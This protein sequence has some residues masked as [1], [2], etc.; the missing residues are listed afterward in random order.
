LRAAGLFMVMV[1]M[2][3]LTSYKATSVFMPLP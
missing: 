2:R 1:A 3:S